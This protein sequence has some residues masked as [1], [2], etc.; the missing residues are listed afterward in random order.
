MR[1]IWEQA[2]LPILA[3]AFL[4]PCMPSDASLPGPRRVRCCARSPAARR[5]AARGLLEES[6]GALRVGCAHGGLREHLGERSGRGG[7]AARRLSCSSARR[8]GDTSPTHD[9]GRAARSVGDGA[10]PPQIAQQLPDPHARIFDEPDRLL[11]SMC[12]LQA[13]RISR[14]GDHGDRLQAGI[15]RR[16][17][18]TPG[19]S[20]PAGGDP[21]ERCPEAC[22]GSLQCALAIGGAHHLWPSCPSRV[23]SASRRWLRRHDQD[24][25]RTARRAQGW[26]RCSARGALRITGFVSQS[27]APGWAQ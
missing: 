14:E 18:T 24:A 22:L 17:V 10:D 13:R 4:R 26:Q 12:A 25:E 9:G 16:R 6:S 21:R 23:S 11:V 3:R 7:Q 27:T 20:R 15:W 8:S 5:G 1:A 19:R 2:V